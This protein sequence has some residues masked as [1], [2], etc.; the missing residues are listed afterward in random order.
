M[1][2]TKPTMKQKL[3]AQEYVRNK[4][5]KTQAVLAV[6]DTKS[7]RNAHS[8]ADDLMVKPVVQEEIKKQLNKA[9]LDLDYLGDSIKSSID[10]NL[11]L[12]KPSQA[13]AMDG[14][15]FLYRLHNVIPA[16]KN[17]NMNYSK[18]VVE[19][20]SYDEIKET[21]EKLNKVTEKLLLDT[22]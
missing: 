1:Q 17:M 5:N 19:N 4:G 11:Q 21:L 16:N 12:G 10:Q 13:V 22:A 3:F 18:K 2:R 8:I 14:I 20:Q 6:Y 9:G 7:K 15:K